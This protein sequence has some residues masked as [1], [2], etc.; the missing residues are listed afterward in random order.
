M[1]SRCVA[2][3][4]G[5]ELLFISWLGSSACS[6]SGVVSECEIGSVGTNVISCPR[7]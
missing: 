1:S 2:G 4:G 7:R 3:L 6:T 5:V